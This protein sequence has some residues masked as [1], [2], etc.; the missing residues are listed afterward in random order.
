MLVNIKL[1]RLGLPNRI[2]VV[3]SSLKFKFDRQ[4]IVDSDSNDLTESTISI[5]DYIRFKIDLFSIK[6][7]FF[8]IKLIF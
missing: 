2:D 8:D 6:S 3:E 1:M 4:I 5:F 7:T